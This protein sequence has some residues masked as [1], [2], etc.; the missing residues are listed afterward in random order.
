MSLKKSFFF[1]TLSSLVIASML[2]AISYILLN[3]IYHS[4]QDKYLQT[5]LYTET[6]TIMQN[7]INQYSDFDKM[8]INII[9]TLQLVLPLVFFIGLLLLADIIFY[10]VKLKI[11][12]EI[13]NKGANEIS[14]NNLDFHLEY[15]SNDELGNLCNAF[16]KMRF[17]LNKNN[18]KMW[19]LIDDRK[20][21]NAAFS[22][23]L[24]NPL[25][26]LKGYSDYLIKYIPTGKLSY[27]KILSTTQLMSEHIDRI[28]YYVDSMSNAQRLEDLVIA[29][30]ISNINGFVEN[31][32]S[33]ICILSKQTGKSFK[34]TNKVD[35]INVLFDENIIHR[36]IENI[37]SNAFRYAKNKVSILIYLEQ[38]FLTFVIEDD[39]IGF[40]KDALNS[41]LKPFYKDK[42]LNNNNSNFGIGLYIAKVLCEKHGGSIAIENNSIGG[43]KIIAKFSTKD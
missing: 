16:E 3:H 42:A 40:S 41:A 20:Q 6:I 2:T 19:T 39:G 31:L 30:S 4:I 33:N 24:R 43:A 37:I 7:N 32:D 9:S 18:I 5:P 15:K 11:P 10:K 34:L 28:E 8:L 38:E 36:V 21:L 13:L 23:D 14:N 26:V 29:K 25:T 22:H 12:I 1:L 27:K 35:N 17:Q